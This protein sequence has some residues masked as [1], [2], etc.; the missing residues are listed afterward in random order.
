MTLIGNQPPAHD[1]DAVADQRFGMRV[2]RDDV[3]GA[4]E[5][6]DRG[7]ADH[8]RLHRRAGCDKSEGSRHCRRGAKTRPQFRKFVEI[9]L[10]KRSLRDGAL[11]RQAPVIVPGRDQNTCEPSKVMGAQEIPGNRGCD[12][13]PRAS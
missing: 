12:P 8:E 10:R 2:E 1:L 11:K 4:I 5:L 7:A 6:D 9:V 3:A 13:F